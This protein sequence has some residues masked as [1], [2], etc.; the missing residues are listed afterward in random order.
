MLFAH[1]LNFFVVWAPIQMT[2]S[3][4]LFAILLEPLFETSTLYRFSI[5]LLL[6]VDGFLRSQ[7]VI[8]GKQSVYNRCLLQNSLPDILLVLHEF[9]EAFDVTSHALDITFVFFPVP[10]SA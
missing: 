6:V 1:I 3:F 4:F 5:D 2:L 8:F 9:W 10:K 7:H